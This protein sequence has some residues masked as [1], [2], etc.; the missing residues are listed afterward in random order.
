MNIFVFD[1]ETIPDISLGKKINNIEDLNDDEALQS[2]NYNHRQNYPNS[3]LLPLFL[4]QIVSISIVLKS[5]SQFKIWS[6]GEESSSEK[7]LLKRFFDGLE[8]YTPTLVSWNGKNFDLPVMHYRALKHSVTSNI[9]WETGKSDPTFKWNNYQNRFHE[10]HLDLMDVIAGYTS[11]AF[12]S[13][14]NISTLIGLPGKMGVDGSQVMNMYK[15][16]E[17]DAIRNYCEIDVLN[18]FLI[19][20]RF[21]LVKGNISLPQY[22]KDI[23][24]VREYLQTSKK[25]HFEKY[26]KNWD[27]STD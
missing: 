17:I 19:F 26:L 22:N 10:R 5:P 16:N 1:I 20:L 12:S 4:Q 15:N 24:Q 9:Y 2:I 13:L 14:Q 8:R 7:E 11:S 27:I 18:T 23:E 3:K 6:L 21:E 25:Q